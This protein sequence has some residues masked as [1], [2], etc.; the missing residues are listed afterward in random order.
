MDILKLI[1]DAVAKGEKYKQAPLSS[2][3]IC[4]CCNLFPHKTW[5][6]LQRREDW[7]YVRAWILGN[8]LSTEAIDHVKKYY[9]EF[10]KWFEEFDQ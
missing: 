1:R 8:R 3:C 10:W 2:D 9:P 6:W 4:G 7:M 5:E